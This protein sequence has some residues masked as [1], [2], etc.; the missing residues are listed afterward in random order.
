VTEGSPSLTYALR[1]LVWN[2]ESEVA[3]ITSLSRRIDA[4]VTALNT[5]RA[6]VAERL[7]RLDAVVEAVDDP[8]FVAVLRARTAAPLPVEDE[9]FPE[10]LYGS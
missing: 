7:A 8:E 2:L 1:Q 4:H 3:I 9:H 6:E 10:R 5:A